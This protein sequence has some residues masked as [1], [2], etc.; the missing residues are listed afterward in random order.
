MRALR[1]T[2]VVILFSLALVWTSAGFAQT[3]S[4]KAS[5]C[6]RQCA[7]CV[8][9]VSNPA[10]P[11]VAPVREAA[12]RDHSERD[13]PDQT[14]LLHLLP[15]ALPKVSNPAGISLPPVG[16]DVSLHARH[17]VFLI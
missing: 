14:L 7:C 16:A 3:P 10:P 11:P 15:E 6:C 1:N 4:G 17:C 2:A 12:Q 13:L 9:P 8:R 5:G